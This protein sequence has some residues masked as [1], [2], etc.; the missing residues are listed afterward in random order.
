[1]TEDKHLILALERL[2]QGDQKFKVILGYIVYS[3]PAWTA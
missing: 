1:M 3:R 2:K